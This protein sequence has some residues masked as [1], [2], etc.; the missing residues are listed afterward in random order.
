MKIDDIDKTKASSLKKGIITNRIVNPLM[1]DYKY[2][3]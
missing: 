3:Q 2:P 1:P